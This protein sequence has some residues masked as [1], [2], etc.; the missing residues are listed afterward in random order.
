MILYIYIYR[1]MLTCPENLCQTRGVSLAPN[2]PACSQKVF[3]GCSHSHQ[4]SV[5]HYLNELR[6]VPMPIKSFT[7]LL[8]KTMDSSPGISWYITVDILWLSNPY[9]DAL[10]H[11]GPHVIFHMDFPAFT[12]EKIT[13]FR[14]PPPWR[15]PA[16][17]EPWHGLR[18]WMAMQMLTTTTAKIIIPGLVN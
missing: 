16:V 11:Y 10:W 9:Q 5:I 2:W 8:K 15:R 1:Y 7:C 6:S 13:Y 17:G 14:L 12:V 3:P 4:V 18:R